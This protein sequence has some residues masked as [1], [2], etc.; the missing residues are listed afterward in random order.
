MVHFL[1]L[2]CRCIANDANY[3]YNNKYRYNHKYRYRY[4]YSI[5]YSYI[6]KQKILFDP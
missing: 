1:S 5:K 3:K 4:N 2:G 6:K